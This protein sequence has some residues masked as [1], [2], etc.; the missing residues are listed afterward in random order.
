MA[1]WGY[2]NCILVIPSSGGM[3][4]YHPGKKGPPRE[5]LPHPDFD[6]HVWHEA[7]ILAHLKTG[8]IRMAV[9]G[10][11]VTRYT[12][13]DP[14][15]LRKGRSACRFTPARPRSSTRT[16]SSKSIPRRTAC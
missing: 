14:T 16:W 8:T 3:W 12:D 4:D 10:V 1:D 6:P 9:N 7:E 11:E 2:G 13:E 15:R 5:K